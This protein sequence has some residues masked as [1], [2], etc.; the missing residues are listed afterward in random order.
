M[1]DTE[2]NAFKDTVHQAHIKWWQDIHTGQP[3]E[4]NRFELLGLIIT[5]LSEATEGERR[6]LMDDKL[7]HR[8]MAEVE[9][10]DAYIRL[11]D[12][13]GGFGY[14]IYRLRRTVNLVFIGRTPPENKGEAIFLLMSAVCSLTPTIR[15]GEVIGE[16][17]TCIEAY[18]DKHGYRLFDAIT[19]KLAFNAQRADHKHENRKLADGKKF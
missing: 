10:A 5:E 8:K 18:C 15:H 12:F 14:T 7:P 13:A 19:E 3:I 2:L 6:N 9:M 4:R 17:L 16:I 1:T 11:L